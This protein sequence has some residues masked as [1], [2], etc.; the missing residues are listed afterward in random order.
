MKFFS[1]VASSEICETLFVCFGCVDG[2]KVGQYS[3]IKKPMSGLVVALCISAEIGSAQPPN[4]QHFPRVG[5]AQLF[6]G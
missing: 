5:A 4:S 6:F 3:E 1:L 2:N